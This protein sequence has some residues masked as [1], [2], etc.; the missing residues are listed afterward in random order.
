M[1]RI[2]ELRQ[3][4]AEL[5]G[6]DDYA[7]YRLEDHMVKSGAR[8]AAFEEE[9]RSLTRV[10]WERDVAELRAHARELG[11][12]E[13]LP[14]D[15]AYVQ[16]SLRRKAYDID[17]EMLRPYLSLE[18]V[19]DGLFGI[20][21]RVFGLT[22]EPVPCAEVWHDNVG[23]YQIHDPGR[24]VPGRVLY[25]LVPAQGE[26]TGSVDGRPALRGTSSRRVV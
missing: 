24:H 9:M 5:L 17:D 20:V 12:A 1:V 16:E 13:L 14:W 23:F 18:T 4:L 3:Q 26:T 15:V 25:R 6:Y 11:L 7:D 2:L 22:V 10:Y 19:M 8:A 21:R